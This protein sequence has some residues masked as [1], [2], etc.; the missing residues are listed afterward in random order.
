MWAE[1]LPRAGRLATIKRN[2]R[3]NLRYFA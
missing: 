1:G 2:W 3:A